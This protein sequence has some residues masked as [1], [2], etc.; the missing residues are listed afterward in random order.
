MAEKKEER[1]LTA[2][3][4]LLSTHSSRATRYALVVLLALSGAGLVLLAWGLIEP[5]LV[6]WRQVRA[7][8]EHLPAHWHGRRIAAFGD[9]QVGAVLANTMTTR[10]VVSHLVEEKPEAVLL[11]GDLI[12]KGAGHASERVNEVVDLVA[13]LARADIP[14]YA[15]LGNHDY[16]VT[17]RDPGGDHRRAA[18]LARALEVAGIRVL[19]NEAIPLTLAQGGNGHR[20]RI[21]EERAGTELYIVG[22]GCHAAGEDDPLKALASVPA[23]APR[24]VVMHHP[25][26]FLELPAHTAPVAVSGH[27]HGRQIRLPGMPKEFY[28]R[29]ARVEKAHLDGWDGGYGQ[30]GNRLYINRGIGFGGLPMRINA[31]PEVTLFV[32]EPA[33]RA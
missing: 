25:N 32:L 12:Y 27:M 6:E 4:R 33:R 16:H 11:L 29:L 7:P 31:R 28:R 15:V 10:R 13:P 5:Y 30:P 3:E 9:V 14:V 2:V 20:D 1:R 23:G 26:S 21:A 24:L 17:D 8:I 19:R 22:V 18:G